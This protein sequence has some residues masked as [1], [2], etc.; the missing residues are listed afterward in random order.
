M[1]R[2]WFTFIVLAIAI[3][4]SA[5]D[6]WLNIYKDDNGIQRVIANPVSDISEVGF[7][8]TSPERYDTMLIS[9]ADAKVAIDMETITKCV[10]GHNV[11]TIYIETDEY[12]TEIPSKDYYLTASFSMKAYGNYDDVK[13]TSVN[14]KGRG[15][16]TWSYDKKPYR[17]KF[18]KK[19]SLCGLAKAKNFA[20]IANYIDP[21]L[22]RNAVAFKIAQLLEMPYTNHSIPVNVVLNGK[23]RGAY[24]FTEKIGLNSGSVD[25][26]DE[27]SAILFEIDTAYDEAYKFK[28]PIYNLPVMVKDPDFDDLVAE[29]SSLTT[30]TLLQKWQDDFNKMERGV[31]NG[32]FSDYIDLKSVVDYVLVYLVTSNQEV[33]HPKSVFLYKGDIGDKYTFGPVWDFDWAYTFYYNDKENASPQRILFDYS[34]LGSNF[35]KA[36]IKTQAFKDAF[37]ERWNYFKYSLWPQ[38]KDYMAEYHDAIEVSAL[39]NGEIWQECNLPSYIASSEN[40]EKYYQKTLDFLEKR[41]EWISEADNFGLY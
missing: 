3:N 26:D 1:K 36:I 16:S 10:I 29:D 39:Q 13:A 12:V 7:T 25:I 33:N 11:P 5:Q 22:M 8:G 15:N 31:Y 9:L 21:T 32:T 24:M 6:N 35:F 18:D 28:S 23:Y 41:I 27:S 14:I 2:Y 38:L 30:T 37:A 40:F 4:C 17:L 19:I 34:L 20:L